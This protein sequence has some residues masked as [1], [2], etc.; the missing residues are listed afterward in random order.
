M[1]CFNET[2]AQAQGMQHQSRSFQYKDSNEVVPTHFQDNAWGVH[3]RMPEI[4]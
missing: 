4:T 3:E 1:D 2:Q